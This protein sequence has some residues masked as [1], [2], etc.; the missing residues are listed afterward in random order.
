MRSPI[1]SAGGG[2]TMC[3]TVQSTHNLPLYVAK[4][5]GE[6]FI[7]AGN[8]E[9]THLNATEVLQQ[10]TCRT[11]I[12]HQTVDILLHLQCDVVHL[13]VQHLVLGIAQHSR[14]SRL[15]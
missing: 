6:E 5:L 1:A 8:D 2:W 14:C 15:I 11:I 10:Q 13:I 9:H 12:Q 7:L 4:V 3:T